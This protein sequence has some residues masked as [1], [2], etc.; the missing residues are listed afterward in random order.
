[1][2]KSILPN[3]QCFIIYSHTNNFSDNKLI[4]LQVTLNLKI[5]ISRSIVIT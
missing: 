2:V 5:T 1:M 3:L 4:F